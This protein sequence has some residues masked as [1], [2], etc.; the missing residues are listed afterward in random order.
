[1]YSVG[2]PELRHSVGADDVGQDR[3]LWTLRSQIEEAIFEDQAFAFG[4]IQ[5]YRGEFLAP[6]LTGDVGV[7]LRHSA[8]ESDTFVG[9]LP[10]EHFLEFGSFRFAGVGNNLDA[11]FRT[12]SR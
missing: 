12:A 2:L 6:R 10:A 4:N 11:I 7:T 5:S 1:M 9:A 3:D 8:R